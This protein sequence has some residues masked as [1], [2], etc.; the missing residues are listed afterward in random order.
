[1]D[2]LSELCADLS[3]TFPEGTLELV[4]GNCISPLADPHS[5]CLTLCL[6][7]CVSLSV[8]HSL[9]LALCLTLCVSLCV[10]LSLSLTLSISLCLALCLA[11]CVS[12]SAL[13]VSLSVSRSVSR[14]LCLALCVSLSLSRCVF[15]MSGCVSPPSPP[16][17][18]VFHTADQFVRNGELTVCASLLGR[19]CVC[20]ARN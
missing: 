14:S 6:T 1:M 11:L 7:L 5:L 13:R 9:C 18:G 20:T 4:N 12:L 19:S 8:S 16:R 10:S 17:P 15:L 3:G 2:V